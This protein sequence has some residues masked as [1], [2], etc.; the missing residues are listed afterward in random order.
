MSRSNSF[1]AALQENQHINPSVSAGWNIS[2]YLV[3]RREVLSR[4]RFTG[5]GYA[6]FVPKVHRASLISKHSLGDHIRSRCL[7]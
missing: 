1:A 2:A 6:N 7:L 3:L 5:R 4:L